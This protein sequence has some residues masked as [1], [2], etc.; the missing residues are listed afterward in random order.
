LGGT[1]SPVRLHAAVQRLGE[2]VEFT[3]SGPLQT[4]IADGTK[5]PAGPSQRGEDISIALQIQGRSHKQ[6]RAAVDK[7]V[8]GFGIGW[9]HWQQSLATGSEPT[10]VVTAAESGLRELVRD[11]YPDA[12]S[13]VG[14]LLKLRLATMYNPDDLARIWLPLRSI[15]AVLVSYP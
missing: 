5:V 13:G 7:R 8:V 4:L 14:N 15:A 10:L 6:G 11:C 3:E 12:V 9:G 1:L 2:R